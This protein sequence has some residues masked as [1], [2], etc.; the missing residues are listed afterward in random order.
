MK[1]ATIATFA[2]SA[3]AFVPIQQGRTATAVQSFEN[4]LGVI[5]PTGFFDP[6]GLSKVR[7]DDSMIMIEKLQVTTSDPP[8][9]N[10]TD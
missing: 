2:G 6:L 1:L 9:I 8:D 3:A 7:I 5:A 4:E 10:Y